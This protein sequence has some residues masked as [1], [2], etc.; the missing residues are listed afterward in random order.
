[1]RIF[2]MRGARFPRMPIRGVKVSEWSRLNSMLEASYRGADHDHRFVHLHQ[3]KPIIDDWCRV[4]EYDPAVETGLGLT[5]KQFVAQCG[6]YPQKVQYGQATLMNGGIRDVAS[7]PVARGKGYGI[8][9]MEDAKKFMFDHHMDCS[10][11]FSGANH[12]YEKLGWRGGMPNFQNILS[13]ADFARWH[14]MASPEVLRIQQEITVRNVTTK[15]FP[16]LSEVH[17]YSLPGQYFAAHRSGPY[18][19]DHYN[20]N[21]STFWDYLVAER[22]GK[23]IAYLVFKLQAEQK[24]VKCLITGMQADPSVGSENTMVFAAI[25][26]AFVTFLEEEGINA[27][28]EHLTK[29]DLRLSHANP[30]VQYFQKMGFNLQEQRG[31][32]LGKMCLITNP[33]TLFERLTPEIQSRAGMKALPK[34]S[35]WVQFDRSGHFPGGVR[36]ANEGKKVIVEVRKENEKVDTWREHN[37]SGFTCATISDLT[38]FFA[39]IIPPGEIH[40]AEGEDYGVQFYGEGKAWLDGLF[41]NITYDHYDLDHY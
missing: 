18:L 12:F 17:N 29:L 33:Y 28:T 15:D 26:K 39:G 34:G 31:A 8:Q 36:I 40:P 5:Q 9:V 14:T 2:K 19:L 1:M 22:G 41:G 30:L 6:I 35:C 20:A 37:P 7:H 13:E 11:L 10:I 23:L 4:Y 24:D 21:Q 38:I 25:I 27:K 16:T 3:Q 32:D